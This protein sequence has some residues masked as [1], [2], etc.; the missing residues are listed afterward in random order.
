MTGSKTFPRHVAK[1][2]G[3][4]F[5]LSPRTLEASMQFDSWGAH[6]PVRAVKGERQHCRRGAGLHIRLPHTAMCG[7]ARRKAA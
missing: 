6:R 4:A 3:G 7:P 5:R 2:Q 1:T